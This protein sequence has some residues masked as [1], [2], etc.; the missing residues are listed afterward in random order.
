MCACA[1][2]EYHNAPIQNT[3]VL[4]EVW[5][6]QLGKGSAMF[7]FSI[8]ACADADVTCCINSG[9]VQ[10]LLGAIAFPVCSCISAL[11]LLAQVI[12]E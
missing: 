4:P 2:K 12:D 9:T 1:E 5:E 3:G 7:C 6:I 11:S 8:T 10:K